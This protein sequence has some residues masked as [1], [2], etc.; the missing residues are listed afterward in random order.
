MQQSIEGGCGFRIVADEGG[1]RIAVRLTE[2]FDDRRL[3]RRPDTEEHR[4]DVG[5]RWG[6]RQIDRA[7]V[8]PDLA[9]GADPEHTGLTR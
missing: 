7:L 2:Q 3:S 5:T 1:G 9:L 8:Q 4:R 6:A